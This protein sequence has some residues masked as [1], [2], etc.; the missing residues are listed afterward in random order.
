MDN[1]ARNAMSARK[2]GMTYGKWK[3]LQP[4]VKVERPLDE[5]ECVCQ[6]CGNTFVKKTRQRRKYC[7]FICSNQAGREREKARREKNNGQG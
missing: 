2:A 5:M 6:F 4:I 1:L 3:A 7:D